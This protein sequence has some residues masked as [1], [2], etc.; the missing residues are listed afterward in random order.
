MTKPMDLKSDLTRE[1]LVYQ[2]GRALAISRGMARSVLGQGIGM[3]FD[4][5]YS[6]EETLNLAGV[7][8]DILEKQKAGHY[9]GMS[10][11]EAMDDALRDHTESSFVLDGGNVKKVPDPQ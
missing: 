11:G 1:E 2:W 4:T 8:W 7:V 5:Q 9:D 6:K 3:C 10:I